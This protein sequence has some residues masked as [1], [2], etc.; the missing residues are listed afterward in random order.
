VTTGG[1]SMGDRDLVRAALESLGVEVLFHGVRLQPGKPALFGRHAKGHVFALP[2][3]PVSAL[4]CADL[5]ALPFAA[6][7]AGLGFDAALRE[8][9][10]VLDAPVAASPKRQRVFPCRLGGGRVAP[11]PWRGSADLYTATRGNA[12][13]VVPTARDLAAGE[14]VTCL[15]PARS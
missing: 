15:V 14:E 12:Y 10:A 4:V 11:L 8:E 5:F 7:R 9:R 2:G 1:V 6:A 13:L 3:N